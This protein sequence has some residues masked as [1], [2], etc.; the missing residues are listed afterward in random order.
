MERR[1][2]TYFPN[3]DERPTDVPIGPEMVEA[4]ESD[5]SSRVGRHSEPYRVRS[6]PLRALH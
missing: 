3:R 2:M 1:E 6:P 5:G 4:D